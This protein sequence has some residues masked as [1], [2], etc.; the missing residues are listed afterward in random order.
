MNYGNLNMPLLKCAVGEQD[1]T[2][3]FSDLVQLQ[4]ETFYIVENNQL[5]LTKASTGS[6]H[7]TYIERN[8]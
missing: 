3:T 4:K 7:I 8:T 5:L 6:D 1:F 2:K